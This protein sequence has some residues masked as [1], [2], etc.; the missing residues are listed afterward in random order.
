MSS[1]RLSWRQAVGRGLWSGTLASVVSAA[2]LA[3]CGKVERNTAAGPMNGPSQW[4]WGRRA[5]YRRDASVRHTVVGYAVHHVSATFWAVLHETAFGGRERL[6]AG[7][8]LRNAAITAGVACFTDYMLTPLRLR[9]G[10]EVQLSRKSLAIVY[11]A[12]AVGL[13]VGEHRLR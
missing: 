8:N 2:A 5:A 9:P 13:A 6:G 7:A 4:I 11:T 12:F 1:G 10:Y 3:I